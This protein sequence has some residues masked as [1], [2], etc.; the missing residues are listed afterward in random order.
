MDMEMD[1]IME[2]LT[3]ADISIPVVILG[4]VAMANRLGVPKKFSPV[5]SL[6]LGIA[7]GFVYL[8]PTDPKA[9]VLFGVVAGLIPVGLFSGVKNV[10]E[11]VKDNKKEVV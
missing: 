7:S 2:M 8:A 6:V 4:L 9:A 3:Y 11:L 5:L 10:A 1:K